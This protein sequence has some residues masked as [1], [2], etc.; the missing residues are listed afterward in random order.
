LGREFEIMNLYFKPYCAC[1]WAQ[2]AV[3]GALAI[4]RDEGLAPD[5]IQTIEV[6]T[7]AEAAALSRAHPRNTEEAQYN[8]AFPIAA[9]LLDG[10]VGP[11]Q[12]LPPRL[13]DGDLQAMVDRVTAVVE[14]RFQAEFPALALAEVVI[15]TI[16]G[17]KL[18]SEVMSASW[19]PASRLPADEELVAKFHWLVDPLLGPERAGRIESTIW[20]FEEHSPVELVKLCMA[21]LQE[22]Q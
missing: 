17:R 8:L 11:R 9:A 10:E 1:R 19:D 22:G 20:R 14:D 4:C 3:D 2:P 6:H 5:D 7:F 13:H 21:P 15:E 18:K 16:D 12:V